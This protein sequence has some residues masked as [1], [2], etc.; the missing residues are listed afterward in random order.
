MSEKKSVEV[1]EEFRLRA[2]KIAAGASLR[3]LRLV[4][5]DFQLV[6]VVEPS[7][8]LS[9]QMNI[10][11][12]AGE[13]EEPNVLVVSAKFGVVIF[14]AD[15]SEH[16]SDKSSDSEQPSNVATINFAYNTAFVV[17]DDCE[18]NEESLEAFAKTTGIF[19]IYPYA[20]EFVTDVTTRAGLPP[21]ILDFLKA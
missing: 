15:E 13:T 14:V 20:R 9:I 4:Q 10:E 16:T 19:A 8:E 18:W 21:L 2:A 6:N 5:S 7:D 17:N 1:P 3:D 11:L 12:S